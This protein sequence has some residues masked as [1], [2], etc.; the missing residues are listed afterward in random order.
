MP[1]CS[2]RHFLSHVGAVAALPPSS[3]AGAA[4]T[5]RAD[6][7]AMADVLGACSAD[8]AFDTAVAMLR[9]GAT[10]ADV[11][12]ATLL[13]GSKEVLP[14]PIGNT[15]H[16]LMMVESSYQLGEQT[17]ADQR[18]FPVLFNLAY[19]KRAQQEHGRWTLPAKP[20]GAA[21]DARDARVLFERGM[22]D[23][24]EELTDR[25]I[26]NLYA[27]SQRDDLF[28]LVW[29]F[30][31][32]DFRFIGHKPIYAAAIYRSA[33]R[34]GWKHAEPVL[35][36]LAL[37]LLDGGGENREWT[38]TWRSNTKLARTMKAPDKVRKPD[39]DASRDLLRTLRDG[40]VADAGPHVAALLERGVHPQ[41]VWDGL[42][43]YAAEILMKQ[44]GIA[45]VH[46]TTTINAIHFI[47]KTSRVES[48]KRL[49]IL[50][51]ASW[52]P[53]F[54]DDFV[55]RR[56]VRLAGPGIDELVAPDSAPEPTEILDVGADARETAARNVLRAADAEDTKA[57]EAAFRRLVFAKGAESHNYKYSAAMLEEFHLCQPEIAPRI[58]AAGAFY[59]PVGGSR[60]ARVYER[61]RK[62]LRKTI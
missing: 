40:T 51:A 28:E 34:V 37:G 7:P 43:L 10:W 15:A 24:S 29:P 21:L 54:R 39:P 48:T 4:Q 19:I 58:L 2:R 36:S 17:T 59:L 9:D 42:R 56:G 38:A 22:R 27:N 49:A 18:M 41:S 52:M 55:T 46:L 20:E 57:L 8:A 26:V 45:G 16:A 3:L 31:L 35:R 6:L 23:W 13:L 60:D 30:A 25:A 5:R 50:Q 12:G 33:G 11:L 53:L 1:E 47:W 62:A 32:R 44:K 61:A 14:Q